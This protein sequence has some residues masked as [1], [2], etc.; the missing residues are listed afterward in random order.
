MGKNQLW[1]NRLNTKGNYIFQAWKVTILI[2]DFPTTFP[3]SG[4]LE[5]CGFPTVNVFQ[6]LLSLRVDND[7]TVATMLE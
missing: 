4:N 5:N 1:Y 7:H 6:F 3:G 2:H